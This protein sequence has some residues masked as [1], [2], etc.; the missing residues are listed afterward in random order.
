MYVHMSYWP[1]RPWNYIDGNTKQVVDVNKG[2]KWKE[3]VF[4]SLLKHLKSYS[5]LDPHASALPYQ[6]HPSEVHSWPQ[7][8]YPSLLS[9]PS[10]CRRPRY[11]AP[12]NLVLSSNLRFSL[13]Q[14]QLEWTSCPGLWADQW[15]FGASLLPPHRH[16]SRHMGRRLDI[17]DGRRQ[18]RAAPCHRP[19][20]GARRPISSCFLLTDRLTP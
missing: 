9:H 16:G 1:W 2:R 20:S 7:T 13:H 10:V 4:L 14:I 17:L 5:I 3:P 11:T 8:P 19:T 6:V 18:V 12:P 15:V